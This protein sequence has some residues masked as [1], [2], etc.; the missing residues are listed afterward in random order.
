MEP[1]N[2]ELVVVNL[3]LKIKR[4][5]TA[6]IV[7]FFLKNFKKEL[8]IKWFTYPKEKRERIRNE[9]RIVEFRRT[10]GKLV[11]LQISTR[12]FHNHTKKF[13]TPKK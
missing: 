3:I 6:K 10:N 12:F 5:F 4:P 8:R 7:H 13:M 11:N 1:Q 9:E 2:F